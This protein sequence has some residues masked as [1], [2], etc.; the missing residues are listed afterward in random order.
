[1]GDWEDLG[2]EGEGLSRGEWVW[3]VGDWWDWAPFR[4]HRPRHPWSGMKG[5][6]TALPYSWLPKVLCG[7]QPSSPDPTQMV[8]KEPTWGTSLPLVSSSL[9]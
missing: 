2:R 7:G 8:R 9:L 5:E 3:G 4:L 1:M 6:A